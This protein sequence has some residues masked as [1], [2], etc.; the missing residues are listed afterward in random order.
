MKYAT[1]R[2]LETH[3]EEASPDH[4]ASLYAILGKDDFHRKTACNRLIHFLLG[5]NKESS[6]ALTTLEGEGLAAKTLSNALCSATLF[7][8]KGWVVIHNSEKLSKPSMEW[9][10][11]YFAKPTPHITLILTAPGLHHGTHFFKKIEKFG[12]V[13]DIA[14]EKPWEKERSCT[15]W[16][17]AFLTGAGKITDPA[18]AQALVKQVGTDGENLRQEM[19]KLICFVGERREISLKDITAICSGVN[20]ETVWQ[21]GEAIFKLDA[22]AALRISHALL[23]EGTAL[24]SLLR[25]IRSQFQTDLQVCAILAGGGSPA[26]VTA[27]FGYMKGSIL[28]RHCQA[29]RHYG[30]KRFREGLLKIDASELQAKNSAPELDLIEVLIARL[31]K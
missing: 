29:A 2:A 11:A 8:Q 24:L 19:E 26:D 27:Q 25:Q 21:L 6:L 18:T 12:V 28:E 9:L 5:P 4:F 15:E 3:L 13:L 17:Q 16:A 7:S 31:T 23:D 30:L 14:D 1:L 20:S 10:E 22:P